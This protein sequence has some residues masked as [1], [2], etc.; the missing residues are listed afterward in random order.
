MV[1]IS[2]G[3]LK[4]GQKIYVLWS[5]KSNIQMVCLVT[6]SN[7]LKTGQKS[8]WKVKCSDFRSSLFRWLLNFLISKNFPAYLFYVQFFK[9]C[10][11]AKC[12]SIFVKVFI[13]LYLF[14]R[15]ALSDL[16][17]EAA[18]ALTN[19]QSLA[20]RKLEVEKR[21]REFEDAQALRALVRGHS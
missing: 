4:T 7:H 17:A 10:T 12:F 15:S 20:S 8:A 2:N 6:R 19:C 18:L 9:C 13:H 5:K 11:N 21:R 16:Q 3:G 1:Q 14:R